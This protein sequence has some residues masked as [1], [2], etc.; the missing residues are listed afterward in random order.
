MAQSS[1]KQDGPGAPNQGGSGGH[2]APQLEMKVNWIEGRD[3]PDLNQA[4]FLVQKFHE[5]AAYNIL[6]SDLKKQ[7]KEW[8]L[9]KMMDVDLGSCT[10]TFNIFPTTGKLLRHTFLDFVP[11]GDVYSIHIGD[12][13]QPQIQIKFPED[14]PGFQQA[15]LWV[16]YFQQIMIH[17]ILH[18][19]FKHTEKVYL[20]MSIPKIDSC[21]DLFKRSDD[22]LEPVSWPVNELTIQHAPSNAPNFIS[23]LLSDLKSKNIKDFLDKFNH[24][25]QWALYSS[26][27][28]AEREIPDELKK[29]KKP[30]TKFMFRTAAGS[31]TYQIVSD[32]E[33]ERD[34][35]ELQEKFSTSTEIHNAR[36]KIS[37][38]D[39]ANAFVYCWEPTMLQIGHLNNVF[40]DPQLRLELLN[41]ADMRYDE[42]NK[43]QILQEKIVL[44]LEDVLVFRD[45]MFDE[46]FH[47]IKESQFEFE[48]QD[49]MQFYEYL[50]LCARWRDKLP[51][52]VCNTEKVVSQHFKFR[53]DQI[54]D[55]EFV[56]GPA[57]H[58]FHFLRLQFHEL[59]HEAQ[60][61][62]FGSADVADVAEL[63]IENK[64][65]C[66]KCYDEIFQGSSKK[67]LTLTQKD[68]FKK[69]YDSSISWLRE[70]LKHY[71]FSFVS[72]A[73]AA[74]VYIFM[75]LMTHKYRQEEQD[76]TNRIRQLMVYYN[77]DLTIDY[78]DETLWNEN[79]RMGILLKYTIV[80]YMHL[81]NNSVNFQQSFGL[82]EFSRQEELIDPQT[83]LHQFFVL[84][85]GM[86]YHFTSMANAYRSC[87]MMYAKES[88]TPDLHDQI[89]DKQQPPMKH[90]P[91]QVQFADQ[92][93]LHGKTI[94]DIILIYLFRNLFA[95]PKNESLSLL[96]GP[97]SPQE[98]QDYPNFYS[99]L[100]YVQNEQKNFDKRINSSQD[101]LYKIITGEIQ[102]SIHSDINP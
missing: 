12:V 38:N 92:N 53:T 7:E 20:L 60:E 76:D 21:W 67:H 65:F 46:L 54:A 97:A 95:D 89:S 32:E 61:L 33:N 63:A 17:S 10:Q 102:N 71:G 78:D 68:A 9:M 40:I 2:S 87:C 14:K 82:P 42:E 11:K 3:L 41:L 83:Y 59:H 48:N 58:C 56:Q 15:A 81:Y 77:G 39:A 79:N 55:A 30:I 45:S 73:D 4:A 80:D 91:Q 66:S 49:V 52:Y 25:R 96:P 8:L 16:R 51:S 62:G 74:W 84:I 98:P 70:R 94:S 28:I 99:N 90:P 1:G 24:L 19:Q 86:Y 85:D 47:T 64:K 88:Y 72:L 57:N 13:V 93:P 31:K 34:F 43:N 29:L 37:F 22:W 6:K 18:S 5:V 36:Q 50:R 101:Q 75:K 44:L 27:I 26:E 23:L 35:S 100:K 69:A